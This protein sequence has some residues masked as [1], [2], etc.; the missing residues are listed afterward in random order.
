MNPHGFLHTPLKRARLPFRHTDICFAIQLSYFTSHLWRMYSTFSFVPSRK[1]IFNLFA[2]QSATPTLWYFLLLNCQTCSCRCC[3]YCVKHN[4]LENCS[5]V[6]NFLR[7]SHRHYD[8]DIR[9]AK[10]CFDSPAPLKTCHRQLFNGVLHR[11]LLF[12]YHF[13]LKIFNFIYCIWQHFNKNLSKFWV[14][15]FS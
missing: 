11:H 10:L 5:M 8:F 9:F 2:R 6:R 12:S 15:L 4:P 7:Q 3:G 14:K 1:K 13:L